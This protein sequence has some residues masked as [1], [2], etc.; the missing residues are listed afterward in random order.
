MKKFKIIILALLFCFF[1][2]SF[3][4]ALTTEEIVNKT[5]SSYRSLKDLAFDYDKTWQSDYFKKEKKSAGKMYFKNPNKY[6]IESK[7]EE[8][9]SDGKLVWVYSKENQQVI[10][11]LAGKSK[12]VFQ[13][14]Q[15][16]SNFK[17][18][19][20][21]KLIVIEKIDEVSCYKL[22]LLPKKE[23]AS[24]RQM[25]LWVDKNNFLAKKMVYSD[26]SDNQT[27]LLFRNF[28]KNSG[29]RDSKFVYKIPSGI[30]VVDMRKEKGE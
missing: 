5:E 12:N 28:K 14:N 8:I 26:E 16:F 22:E 24:I 29:L 11:N 18:D 9:V 27:I 30:E 23:S 17:N 4:F 1:S 21:I 19:Y 15:I 10:I 6:R 2:A 7:D 13:P 25:Q 3:S 20:H